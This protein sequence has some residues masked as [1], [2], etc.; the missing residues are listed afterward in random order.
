MQGGEARGRYSIIGLKPDLIWRCRDG[1]AEI[2]SRARSAPHDFVPEA[3]PPLASL[4]SLVEATRMTLPPG[5]P[6]MAVGLFGFLGYDMIRLIERLGPPRPIRSTCPTPCWC[7]PPSPRSSIPSAT[8][9][10]SS[11]RYGRKP[12]S[13]RA[14]PMHG[15]ASG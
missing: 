4:R 5:L 2:N 13:T 9:S 8:R 1:R 11:R 3:A 12:A 7:G 10:S 15:P 6:P 14:P